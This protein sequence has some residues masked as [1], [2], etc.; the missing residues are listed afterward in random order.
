MTRLEY[1]FYD[2][3]FLLAPKMDPGEFQRSFEAAVSE[4]FD[5]IARVN[6]K[7]HIRRGLIPEVLIWRL[8]D[9][10]KDGT[11]VE[12]LSVTASELP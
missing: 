2:I 7:T 5:L 3:G 4:R 1:L 12:V 6:G 9:Y 8:M 10:G 11:T